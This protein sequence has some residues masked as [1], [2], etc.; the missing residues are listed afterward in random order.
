MS[1]SSST[2]ERISWH[3]YIL[4]TDTAYILQMVKRHIRISWHRYILFTDRHTHTVY[5]IFA[6]CAVSDIGRGFF[7]VCAVADIGN[8]DTAYFPIT[9]LD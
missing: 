2:W 9:G 4:F 7:A 8:G 6:V 5:R 3:R 1:T